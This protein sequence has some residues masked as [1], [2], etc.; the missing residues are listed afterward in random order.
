M[1]YF[2]KSKKR[3][4]SYAQWNTYFEQNNAQRLLISFEDDRLT[5]K[6]KALIFPSIC[7]FERR[8]YSDGRHL[9]RVADRFAAETQNK[10][11]M[12]CIRWF[13]KEEDAHSNYLKTYMEHYNVR[14]K[15]HVILDHI[16]RQLR[17]LA[18]LRCEVIVLV[19]AEMIA[20]SY[21]DALQHAAGFPALKAI[22]R[23]M[24]HDEMP[25]I[26]S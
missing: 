1:I 18:G 26:S 11:Y 14:E 2:I 10:D 5:E 9:K 12:H 8:E 15:K 22:C 4:F 20:L 24:L 13:I 7:Q 16:F 6:E 21:Y 3:H 23:Q 17:K 19:T 25:H